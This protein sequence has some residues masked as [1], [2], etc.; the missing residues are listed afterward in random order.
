[1]YPKAH[2]IEDKEIDPEYVQ[3]VWY[4]INCDSVLDAPNC[5]AQISSLLLSH[6]IKIFFIVCETYQ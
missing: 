4:D 3:F 2:S 6:E 5:K 1:M